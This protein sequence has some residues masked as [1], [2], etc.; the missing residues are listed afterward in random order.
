MHVF[1]SSLSNLQNLGAL[2]YLLVF[3]IAFGESFVFTGMFVPGT[4]F[5]VIAGG[6]AAHGDYSFWGI[7]CSS[8][9]ASFL[10][11]GLSYELGRRGRTHLD[12]RPFLKKHIERAKPFFKR[13]QGKSIILGRF[14][15]PTRPVIPFLAGVADMQRSHYY[16]LSMVSGLL[17]SIGYAAIGYIFGAAW[18]VALIWS[19]RLLLFVIIIGF[20][21]FAF[22]SFWRWVIAQG[23]PYFMLA[24]GFLYRKL[25]IVLAFPS[26]RRWRKRNK[27]LLR[28]FARRFSLKGFT[29]LPLTGLTIAFLTSAAFFMG[30]ADDYLTGEPSTVFDI[31]LENLLYIFRSDILLSFFRAVSILA[32]WRTV[33][34]AALMLTGLYWYRNRKQYCAPLWINLLLSELIMTGTRLLFHRPRP[35]GLVP[36]VP[37]DIYSFPS[38]HATIAAAFYG[39]I[40]YVW[41]RSSPR[42]KSKV[43]AIFIAFSAI[44]LVDFSRLYLGVHFLNDVLAGNFVGFTTLFFSVSV[45]EWLLWKWRMQKYPKGKPWDSLIVVVSCSVI[46]VLFVFI[47]YPSDWTFVSPTPQLAMIHTADVPTLFTQGLLPRFTETLLGK[48]QEPLSFVIVGQ[49]QCLL[50]AFDDAHWKRADQITVDTTMKISKAAFLNQEFPSAPITPYFYD[51][52]PHN[53]GFEKET[54]MR[55]IRSRHHARIWETDYETPDGQVFVGTASFDTHLKWAIT[56]SIAPDIDTERELLLN[57]IRQAGVIRHLKTLSFVPPMSGKNFTGD[58][59]F[60][61]GKAEFIVLKP[62]N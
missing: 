58:S 55:T 42:W 5:V 62:C 8:V 29:G 46:A 10:G 33:T 32:D 27:I 26:V 40:A 15:G 4:V 12:R 57:D 51:T 3:L 16:P 59:F 22:I 41:I 17:W 52:F 50:Q 49:K 61:D 18:K 45:C 34:I 30:I 20:C 7:V 38:S 37:G 28:F 13:H 25:R 19:S 54:P 39:F 43:S 21:L 35:E 48:P 56:H 31:Q 44:F 24:S 23:K 9:L 1:F 60:T 47:E 36:A 2:G 53:L 14:I 11:D 6:F